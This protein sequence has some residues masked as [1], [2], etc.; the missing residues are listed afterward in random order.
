MKKHKLLMLFVT[1]L[2]LLFG[3]SA[4]A[5][6]TFTGLSGSDFGG[7]EG[8]Q[9]IVDGTN[10]KWGT[11]DGWYGNTVHSIF[12]AS[13]PI[14]VADYELVIANDTPGD[15]GRNWKKWR[16]FG[17]NFAIDGEA[18]LDAE[19]W[20]LLDEKD[21]NL[22]TGEGN[23]SFLVVPLSLSNPTTE[24]Y[25]YFMI[26][27]DE[28]AGGWGNYCQMGE[29]RFTDYTFDP[30]DY[31]NFDPSVEEEFVGPYNEKLSVLRTAIESGEEDKIVAAVADIAPLKR[32]IVSYQEY[33]S[34][35]PSVEAEFVGSYNETLS[36][37]KA[38]IVNGEEDKIV[39]AVTD[40]ALLKK[41]IILYPKYK[42]FDLTGAEADLIVTYNDKMAILKTAITETNNNSISA[43]LADLPELQNEI[44]T[45]RNGKFYAID[46][47]NC[48]GDGPGSNLVDKNEDTKWGGSFPEEGEHVQYVVFRGKEMQ[49]FF[50]K[51]VTGGDTGTYTKR[52]WKTWKVFGAN[53][54]N[55]A[56]ATRTSSDWI[57]LDER[58]DVNEEYLPMKDTYPAT[59][60][61]SKGVKQAYSYY[62]V[63]VYASGGDQQ[64]MS[65][66]YL[67]TRE[68][69]EAIREPLV[70]AIEGFDPTALKVMPEDEALKEEFARL[71]VEL[72]TTSDAVRLTKVY[73]ELVALKEK[74]EE[75]AAYFAGGYRSVA[76]NTAWGDNE[77]WT[78]LIDGDYS[79]KWGG[80]MPE[81]GSYNIFKS[82]YGLDPE[83]YMLITGNDTGRSPGRNWKAW[84][85]YGANFDSDAEAKR[86]TSAWVLLDSKE[87]IGQDLLPGENF[88]PAYFDVEGDFT[89]DEGFKYIKIEV[90]E[91]YDGNSIQMSEFKFLTSGEWKPIRQEYVDSLNKL[92]EEVFEGK[93]I[94]DDIAADVKNA[95]RAVEKAKPGKLLPLFAAAWE[96]IV[97]APKNSWL[98]KYQLTEVD[99]V[100]QI[101]T[102]ADL[103][104]Y[105]KV[106][107]DGNTN[108]EISFIDAVLTADINLSEAIVDDSWTSIGNKNVP[109]KGKFDGHGYTIS[110]ITYTATGEYN[111]LFGK[112]STDAV[113]KNFTAEGT[114]SIS[115]GVT[116]R[117][118]A[119]IAAAGD[120]PVLIQN[121]ISKMNYNNALAGA[122]VG[123]VLGGA[124]NGNA[125]TVD[126]CIYS[127][128]L[129]GNDA[130][131]SGN[132]GGLVG[133][134]NNSGDCY[135]NITNCLFDGELVNTAATPGGC[136]YGGIIGYSNGAHVAINNCLCIGTIQSAVVA[137][138]FGAVKSTRS[139]I[140]NSYY[141]GEYAS[142]NGSPS[143]VTLN[144]QEATKITDEQ[145]KN[146]YVASK[147]APVF[148]QNIGTDEIPVLD[149]THGYVAEIT[150]A[151]WATQYIQEED[152]EIPEGVAAFAG[153][154]VMGG[155]LDLKPIE[156]KIAAREPVVL[157]GAAGFYS[158]M[159]TTEAVKAEQND[160]KG[161]AEDI[162]A[163]GKYILAQPEG[164]PAGFYLADKGIIKAGKAYL[165][166]AAG[167]KC[168][169]FN[170]EG[171]TAIESISVITP[172]NGAIYNI[173]GQRVSKLQK[174]INIVNGKKILK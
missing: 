18:T 99:G 146:G 164:K 47:T 86:D 111:G 38:A 58:T 124:L 52:N 157:K 103:A 87:D 82:N 75:S 104:N 68:E 126:R 138:F 149:P 121:I 2:L 120:G 84:K 170:E 173:S 46:W 25:S 148:R 90:S 141:K 110:N 26:I 169:I 64:Q 154:E 31:I 174:G 123:G 160:L 62:K 107:N 51:L 57:L 5:G 158:F 133:Y 172:A 114:M 71:L 161:A 88:A 41:A 136:T 17:G 144:P 139:T 19:G 92:K 78:K 69:F 97:N 27:V 168:F 16:V 70:A 4:N 65:E 14:A 132:Y 30:Q 165:E 115:T 21:E 60:D 153:V 118:V 8:A 101:G 143:T 116:G 37:L 35:D 73:N 167:T 43:A 61:F 128:K 45:I 29:F 77:N 42:D 163:A 113:V 150:A 79:T 135:L 106:I 11:W 129:D 137:P 39:A 93:E 74:L 9:M 108:T 6:I 55:E 48:W 80:G 33:K 13:I 28:L 53:F 3:Q 140:V 56:A 91:A 20:V 166:S 24:C 34:F 105:A 98:A 10:D 102:A 122:Q 151:G 156:G 145:L 155:F 76:G 1:A 94:A 63:E 22:P 119:L 49:P 130:D 59:F 81:G 7:G 96:A 40:I 85:I 142:V 112:L 67:C 100:L 147:M 109:Y 36:T 23:N 54:E 162:Q 32:K 83:Y 44:N 117:A 152:V 15:P 89:A 66:M 159:P 171:E 131:G 125:T 95:I 12:K 50:Y 127:G 72:K 134:A